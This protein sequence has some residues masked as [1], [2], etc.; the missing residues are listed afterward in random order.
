MV[1]LQLVVVFLQFPTKLFEL[2]L[3]SGLLAGFVTTRILLL[4]NLIGPLLVFRALAL[5]AFHVSKKLGDLF[6]QMVYFVQVVHLMGS[7]DK[8]S[9]MLLNLP[10]YGP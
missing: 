9:V 3:Q 8:F 5:K 10:V 2:L 4:L 1:V 6:R 7:R